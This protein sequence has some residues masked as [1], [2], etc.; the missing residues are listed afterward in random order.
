MY[1]GDQHPVGRLSV[2]GTLV[3][4]QEQDSPGGGFDINDL[5]AGET[6]CTSINFYLCLVSMI[7]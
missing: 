6:F 1:T 2:G 7:D 5:F 3:L 4:G